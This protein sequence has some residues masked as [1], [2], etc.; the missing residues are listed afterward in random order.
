MKTFLISKCF[1][2]PCLFYPSSAVFASILKSIQN[3]CECRFFSRDLSK[4]ILNFSKTVCTIFMK[5]CTVILHPKVLP[6]AHWNQ[7]CMT[8][9]GESQNL[10]KN[11]QMTKY[12]FFSTRCKLL[13]R[14]SG[15]RSDLKKV[16]AF[17]SLFHETCACLIW[18]VIFKKILQHPC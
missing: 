1:F 5:F 11:D 18:S 16:P 17:L 6:R 13:Y 4:K 2:Y 9:I 12:V 3:R 7:N 8:E 10:S 14:G 15:L